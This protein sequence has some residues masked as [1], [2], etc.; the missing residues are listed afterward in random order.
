VVVLDRLVEDH[1]QRSSSFLID[2]KPS[3][4]AGDRSR[5]KGR[6]ER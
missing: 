1:R 4:A 2:A 5:D 6:A 3:G